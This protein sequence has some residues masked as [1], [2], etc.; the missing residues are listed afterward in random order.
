MPLTL[1]IMTQTLH[2][3]LS[4][5]MSYCFS[6]GYV[7]LKNM[8]QLVLDKNSIIMRRGSFYSVPYK[9]ISVYR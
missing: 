3:S 8:D 5:N 2:K 6:Y 1:K 7:W 9:Q 4:L